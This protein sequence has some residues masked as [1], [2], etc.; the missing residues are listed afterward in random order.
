VAFAQKGV[1]GAGGVQLLWA[2]A[3]SSPHDP[4]GRGLFATGILPS[5]TNSRWI[6]RDRNDC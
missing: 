1:R 6:E 4:R 3:G 5:S 2:L